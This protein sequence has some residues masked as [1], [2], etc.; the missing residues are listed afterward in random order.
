MNMLIA[1]VHTLVSAGFLFS[2]LCAGFSVRRIPMWW[3]SLSCVVQA[4]SRHQISLLHSMFRTSWG[5]WPMKAT[6]S[7]SSYT[8]LWL[9]WWT[10]VM[11][12][13]VWLNVPGVSHKDQTLVVKNHWEICTGRFGLGAMH[14]E[15]RVQSCCSHVS[16]R[17]RIGEQSE[18]PNGLAPRDYHVPDR[19][20]FTPLYNS[21]LCLTLV[22][23]MP[24]S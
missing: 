5:L 17:L 20:V 18:F 13:E 23:R 6:D 4:H 2:L 24:C 3:R 7:H 12:M 19:V 8:T 9:W 21:L 14:A 1:T 16:N 11:C 10:S 22:K 15:V